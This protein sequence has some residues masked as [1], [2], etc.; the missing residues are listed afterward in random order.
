MTKTISPEVLEKLCSFTGPTIS[1]AIETF[2]VRARTVGYASMELRCQ[3]P[4]LKPMVGYAV[5]CT[6][7]TTTPSIPDQG[8]FDKLGE[9]FDMVLN[10]P[11]PVV[12]VIKYTGS[13][14]LR[15]C[16]VGDIAT[17]LF[18]KLGAVGIVTDCGFRDLSGIHKRTPEFQIFSPG[19]VCSHGIVNYLE[20]DIV[21]S[22]CGQTIKTGDL[23]YGDENGL[24]NIPIG[25]I[26]V[27]SLIEKAQYIVREEQKVIDF[28]N[29]SS[30][31]FE[32]MKKRLLPKDG[33]LEWE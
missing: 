12:V 23:L 16:C 1:N 25:L 27:E 24:L 19:L 5:T 15:S 29:G 18:Q 4:E 6:L 13:D 10:G 26:D 21:V 7:D 9:L 17:T 3:I 31:S 28:I 33:K 2:N 22:L 32:E 14:R 11:K 8:R 30:Y 20:V